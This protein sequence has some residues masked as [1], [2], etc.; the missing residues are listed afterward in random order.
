M[1][2]ENA[3]AIIDSGLAPSDSRE[4]AI[5]ATLGPGAYTAVVT[6]VDGTANIAL[7]EVFDLDSVNTPQLLNISTR[8]QIDTGEGVMIAGLIVG[9]TTTK[10]VV[11][12]GLGP[13]LATAASPIANPLPNPTLTLFDSLS[14]VI[15]TNDNWQDTQ[16]IDIANTGLA[17]SNSLEAAILAVLPPGN[18][19]AV[20]QDLNGASGV[21]LVEIYNVT[22]GP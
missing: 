9:G 22:T 8:G 5:F 14:Q 16:A 2:S 12:R 4:S 21:G 10:A 17:P 18:Y 20:L 11:I 15:A 1:E 7:V 13:S 19:T 3:Q 6:G